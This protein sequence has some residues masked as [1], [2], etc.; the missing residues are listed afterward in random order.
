[1]TTS[2]SAIYDAL[3]ALVVATLTS[4]KR[5]PTPYEP[6]R[7]PGIILANGYAITFGPGEDMRKTLSN[8]VLIR[9]DFGLV[10][11]RLVAAT[12]TDATTRGSIEKQLFED[13]LSLID[14]IHTNGALHGGGT[15]SDAGYVGDGGIELLATADAAGRYYVLTSVFQ[16]TYLEQL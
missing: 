5:I 4:A 8:Q 12:D 6:E 1:M 2:I 9:R 14:A 11:T 16:I 7:S 3:H 15:A 10:L 13:Q